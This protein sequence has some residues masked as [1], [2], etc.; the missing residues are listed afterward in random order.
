MIGP[1]AHIA[2]A[3]AS[4]AVRT[5]GRGDRLGTERIFTALRLRRQ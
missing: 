5:L 4:G 2:T 1:A 3:I